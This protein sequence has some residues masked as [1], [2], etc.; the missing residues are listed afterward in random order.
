MRNILLLIQIFVIIGFNSYSQDYSTWGEIYDY[1]V[2]DVF[3]RKE[4]LIYNGW[5]PWTKLIVQTVTDVE[6]SIGNDTAYYQFW[7]E[8]AYQEHPDTTWIFDYYSSTASY[9][10]LNTYCIADTV[11]H[12]PDFYGRKLSYIED[13]STGSD[14]KWRKYVDGCGQVN[15]FMEHID[16][17]GNPSWQEIKELVYYIKGN[18]EWGTPNPIVS[19]EENIDLDE[20]IYLF[21]NPTSNIL[22]I[23]II[24]EGDIYMIFVYNNTGK[25]VKSYDG[26][27]NFINVSELQLG[28]YFL[29]IQTRNGWISKRFIKQ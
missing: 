23:S 13:Y 7:N 5:S 1:E 29:R 9:V 17:T 27:I 10:N 20:S 18:E 19:I 14:T 15:F 2:G 22:N 3:H 4:Y 8:T 12:S 28:Y 21:P 6:Y 11:Y 24:G 25:L 26:G 16:P